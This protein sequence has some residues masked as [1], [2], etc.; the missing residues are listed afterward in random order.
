MGRPFL[1]TGKA[2]ID[3][4]EGKLTLR[5]GDEKVDFCM[6]K[7]MKYPLEDETCIKIVAINECVKE[8]NFSL[9][10]SNDDEEKDMELESEKEEE[11][12][13]I[14]LELFVRSDNPTPPSI[15]RPPKLE[16]KP[17]PSHLRYAFLSDNNTLPIIISN[18]LTIE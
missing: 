2:L 17:L 9:G 14:K 10:E 5:V 3:V 12:T 8:V 16:L 1:N 4:H 6:S 7:L 15:E 11:Q 13:F 18:K